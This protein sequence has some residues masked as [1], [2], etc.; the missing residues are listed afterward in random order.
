[1]VQKN[2][3]GHKQ[4]SQTVF[5]WIVSR[6]DSDNAMKPYKEAR[7]TFTHQKNSSI[8]GWCILTACPPASVSCLTRFSP[9]LLPWNKMC[10]RLGIKLAFPERPQFH[11]EQPHFEY[12]GLYASQSHSLSSEV[13]SCPTT[14]ES[15]DKL[16]VE[17]KLGDWQPSSFPV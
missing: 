4:T 5:F 2:S 14:R 8:A 10:T 15:F 12:F 17:N 6:E 9:R 11:N 3:Q 16:A 7:T 13:Q 1:M